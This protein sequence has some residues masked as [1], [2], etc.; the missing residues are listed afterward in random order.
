[1]SLAMSPLLLKFASALA[2]SLSAAA[3]APC[4]SPL[5]CALNGECGADGSCVCDAGWRG[6]DCSAL[7][8]LPA[9]QASGLHVENVSSWGGSVLPYVD[10]A[11]GETTLFASVFENCGLTSWTRNSYIARATSGAGGIDAPF[12]VAGT[13]IPIWSHNVVALNATGFEAA[14]I[15]E[16]AAELR[17][18][19]G[20]GQAFLIFHIGDGRQSN[21]SLQACS[22]DGGALALPAGDVEAAAAAAAAQAAASSNGTSKCGLLWFPWC[23]ARARV[24]Y[25]D[26]ARRAHAWPRPTLPRIASP[27]PVSCPSLQRAA[28]DVRRHA[29][30]RRVQL[31]YILVQRRRRLGAGGAGREGAGRRGAARRGPPRRRELRRSHQGRDAGLV[32]GARRVRGRGGGRLRGH[33]R[34][35]LLRGLERAQQLP[36]RNAIWRR[37]R[38]PA[39]ERAVEHVGPQERDGARAGAAVEPRGATP[40]PAPAPGRPRAARRRGRLDLS[41]VLF[42]VSARA[43]DDRAGQHDLADKRFV[44]RA[45]LA[46]ARTLFARSH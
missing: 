42:D 43:V 39:A 10:P 19:G 21:S 15:A 12:A 18:D 34:L 36:V 5:D 7:D 45:R 26:L 13:A 37:A 40:A 4:A 38:G 31:L 46:L 24:C 6:D 29:E 2:L 8:L 44:P 23:V 35:R 20:G 1:M 27:H 9:P 17:G 14:G 33:A 25:T 16:A 32:R 11:T 22:P 28:A 41:R 30:R 3:A